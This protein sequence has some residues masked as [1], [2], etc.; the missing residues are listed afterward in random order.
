MKGKKRRMV[1]LKLHALISEVRKRVRARENR[2]NNESLMVGK[3]EIKNSY[4][5]II[6]VDKDEIE[7]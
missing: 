1:C 5:F 4:Y 2:D 6:E 3:F 7:K